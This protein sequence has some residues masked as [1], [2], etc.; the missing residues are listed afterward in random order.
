MKPGALQT[1]R[2]GASTFWAARVGALGIALAALGF[3][4]AF[5][6]DATPCAGLSAQ[7]IAG[8][9]VTSAKLMPADPGQGLPQYCEVKATASPTQGS[10]IGLVFRLPEGWNGKM[11]GLGGG[12]WAGNVTLAAA[13]EGLSKRFATAQTDTGHPSTDLADL[14]WTLTASGVQNGDAM[15]DFAYRAVHVMTMT[16]K[17][18]LDRYYGH[19]ANRA[20]FQG[21]STGGRQGLME[22]Q[23]F[24]DDY[25]GVIAGAPVYDF[26]VQTSAVVR[27]QMFHADPQSNLAPEQAL[28]VNKAVLEA[29]DAN[30]GLRDGVITDPR[31]CRWDPEVLQCKAAHFPPECL[32]P[33]QVETVREAYRGLRLKDGQVV[34]WPLM[35]GG[36]LEWV[37]RSI[38]N[39][40]APLGQN[41]QLGF[42]A[43]QYLIYGDPSRNLL[44]VAPET[45]L[46][47][48]SASPYAPLYEAKNPDIAAFAR[49]GGKLLLYH[50]VYDPGPSPLGTIRY[51]QAAKTALGPH[52]EQIQLFLAPGMY[53]C[54]GGPGPDQ[55]KALDAL[56][57]WISTSRPPVSV[58]AFSRETGKQWPL[59]A[60]PNFPTYDGKG[61]PK[62]SASFSC[63][64]KAAA[65]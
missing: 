58:A 30:D 27:T 12:G 43:V 60:Y 5:A 34:D 24:P 4:P 19:P 38:G 33:K 50:G 3:T 11:L 51:Y 53:H 23:R 54:R 39:P 47:D 21:C 26:L 37:D 20:Y 55:I 65:R 14:S 48:I 13:A 63:R 40:K 36:E 10:H 22:V 46:H 16:G 6:A 42:R 64:A 1:G 41:A 2:W 7:P 29:C 44:T 56:D 9:A 18:L 62:A 59:C 17:Q 32:T 35:R 49:H 15:T 52:A 57:Q 31:T 8:L 28:L 45:L 25:D 61:E